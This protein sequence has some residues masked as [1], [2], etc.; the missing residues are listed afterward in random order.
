MNIRVQKI[1]LHRSAHQD[2]VFIFTPIQL[3][4]VDYLSIYLQFPVGIGEQWVKDNFIPLQNFEIV[5]D[6]MEVCA[7][8]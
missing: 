6:E 3:N 2:T 1:V 7:P 5:C 4:E 8:V